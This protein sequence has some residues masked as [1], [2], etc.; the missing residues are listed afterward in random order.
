MPA[1][2]QNY[3]RQVFADVPLT[4]SL[5]PISTGVPA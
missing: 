4:G 1:E 2:T 3:V 5:I